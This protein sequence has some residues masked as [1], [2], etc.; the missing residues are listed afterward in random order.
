MKIKTKVTVSPQ[1]GGKIVNKATDKGVIA[2]IFKQ[3][4]QL[5]LK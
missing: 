3:L 1:N 4:M 2:K 5:N